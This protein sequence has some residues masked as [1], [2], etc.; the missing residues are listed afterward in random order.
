MLTRSTGKNTNT[1][2]LPK[3]GPKDWNWRSR[4]A[5][6]PSP[7]GGAWGAEEGRTSSPL[8]WGWGVAG[9]ERCRGAS[10]LP[11]GTAGAPEPRGGA[12][13]R[14]CSATSPRSPSQAL[15]APHGGSDPHPCPGPEQSRAAVGRGSVCQ[16]RPLPLHG[17]VFPPPSWWLGNCRCPSAQSLEA[18]LGS[19]P[20]TPPGM[21]W[22]LLLTERHLSALGALLRLTMSV[23]TS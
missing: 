6:P 17:W 12:A 5:T 16:V 19:L 8:G 10:W 21:G 9:G 2:V 18:H 1:H 11:V 20:H 13:D 15:R 7:R 4:V 22:T 23:P 14:V 3:P